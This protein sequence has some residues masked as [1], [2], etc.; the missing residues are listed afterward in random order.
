MIYMY[1]I[2]AGIFILSIFLFFLAFKVLRILLKI[3]LLAVSA[4]MI[5]LVIF[6]F[7][8]IS[9][10]KD[11]KDH[12]NTD[13]SIILIEANGTYVA[14][15][16]YMPGGGLEEIDLEELARY[17]NMTKDDIVEGHY[18]ILIFSPE[19]IKPEEQMRTLEKP[20]AIIKAYKEGEIVIYPEMKTTKFIKR[21]P[22][23]VIDKILQKI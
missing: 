9:D 1:V 2:L 11:V 3:V 19:E 16:I 22:T 12:L 17:N 5:I 8:I 21:I 13:T 4:A 20:I 18:K 6:S 23:G 14:G 7:V 10:I 15:R